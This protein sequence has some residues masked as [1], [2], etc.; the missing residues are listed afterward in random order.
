MKIETQ[1][2][3]ISGFHF[4]HFHFEQQPDF[5]REKLILLRIKHIIDIARTNSPYYSE[6]FANAPELRS[7][8]DLS[9]YP[10]LTRET[11]VK[12]GGMGRLLTAPVEAGGLVITTSGGTTG[13]PKWILREASERRSYGTVVARYLNR[14]VVNSRDMI[15]NHIGSGHL[16][17][18]FNA[19]QEI[20]ELSGANTLPFGTASPE[21]VIRAWRTWRPTILLSLPSSIMDLLNQI[22]EKGVDLSE[23]YKMFHTMIYGGEHLNPAQRQKLVDFLGIERFVSYYSSTDT[24]AIAQELCATRPG[25]MHLLSDVNYIEIVDI[26]DLERGNLYPKPVKPGKAGAIVATNL[27][28]KRAPVIRFVIGDLGILR[29]ADCDCGIKTQVLEVLGRIDDQLNV[30]AEKWP[31]EASLKMIASFFEN[32]ITGVG[33]FVVSREGEKTKITLFLESG[34]L[35]EAQQIITPDKVINLICQSAEVY[36]VHPEDI[37]GENVIYEVKILP[38]DTI[39]RKPTTGKVSLVKWE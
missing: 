16:W 29:P 39:P 7:L 36:N 38:P 9:Y 5:V 3:S 15:A 14:Y 8:S 20:M 22:N 25:T 26:D 18:S 28:Y 10:V 31:A 2:N 13:T 12:E 27:H 4:E 1:N 37:T 32:L 33:Q 6:A 11:F 30:K 19:L 34:R 17:A 23:F 21:I 24:G 35:E